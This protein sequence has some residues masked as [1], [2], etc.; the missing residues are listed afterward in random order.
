MADPVPPTNNGLGSVLQAAGVD[1]NAYKEWLASQGG[2]GSGSTSTKAVTLVPAYRIPTA[3]HPNDPTGEALSGGLSEHSA[4]GVTAPPKAAPTLRDSDDVKLDINRMTDTQLEALGER[5]VQANLLPDDW[6]LSGGRDALE[7][8]W[9]TLVDR[10][11]AYNTANGPGTQTDP[12]DKSAA[13]TGSLLT[14]EDMIDLYSGQSPAG[15]NQGSSAPSTSTSINYGQTLTAD[16]ARRMLTTMM[17]GALGR[18]PTD[19]ETDDFQAALNAAQANNP[20]TT[21]DVTVKDARGN[22]VTTRH[23]TGGFDAQDFQAGYTKDKLQGSDEYKHYQAATTYYQALIDAVSA[24]TGL[25]HV[26]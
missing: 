17:K 1:P 13:V 18:A 6:A 24:P 3:A 5:L 7:K 20:T 10:A 4:L 12:N 16:G 8:V 14:P 15:K 21:T 26:Q 22:D 25:V 2:D 9:G 11:A 23:S 19:K